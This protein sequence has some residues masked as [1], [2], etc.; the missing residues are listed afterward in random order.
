MS[1]SALN[2]GRQMMAF[3]G[4]IVPQQRLGSRPNAGG[5]FTPNTLEAAFVLRSS[6]DYQ[7]EK[8]FLDQYKARMQN[9]LNE[10]QQRLQEAY[11]NVLNVSMSQQIGEGEDGNG[12][13]IPDN[14]SL[15]ADTILDGN[16]ISVLPGVAGENAFEDLGIDPNTQTS[17]DYIDRSNNSG[18]DIWRAPGKTADLLDGNTFADDGIEG[19]G[20]RLDSDIA[21]SPEVQFRA[22]NARTTAAGNV[23]SKM[24]ITMRVEDDPAIPTPI[25]GALDF[26]NDV[27]SSIIGGPP[28]PTY[29]NQKV[30]QFSTETKTGGFWSTVNYLYNFAPREIK[31]SYAVGYTVNTDE[32]G[33]DEYL[34]DGELVNERDIPEHYSGDPQ[35]YVT[36]DNR[37]KW[38]SFDPTEGYQHERSG[39]SSAYPNVI[40]R[41]RVWMRYDQAQSSASG[42][43][44]YTAAGGVQIQGE[45]ASGEKVLWNGFDSNDDG[46]AS[47]DEVFNIEEGEVSII[48]G[49]IFQ[50]GTYTYQ[51]FFVNDTDYNNA[52]KQQVLAEVAGTSDGGGNSV[53]QTQGINRIDLNNDGD[54]SDPGESATL[55]DLLTES[56]IEYG[57]LF[58]HNVGMTA[59]REDDINAP[60]PTTDLQINARGAMRSSL[61]Y[62]HYEVETRTVEFNNANRKDVIEL[63]GE[64]AAQNGEADLIDRTNTTDDDGVGKIYAYGGIERSYSIDASK[65]YDL[66]Q[67]D[68]TDPTSAKT[69]TRATGNVNNSFN[70]EFVQ[71]LHKIH[72]VNGQ[73]IVGNEKRQASPTLGGFDLGSYE[74][75]LKSHAM[76]RNLVDFE[77]PTSL[78][79]N[80]SSAV[81]TDWYNAELLATADPTQPLG[82]Q[83]NGFV[84]FPMVE[85][86]ELLANSGVFETLYSDTTQGYGRE[87][88]PRQVIQARN[89]F[90]LEKDELM[91]LEPSTNWVT[92]AA[93]VSRPTYVKR[94]YNVQFDFT[95]VHY[96]P[97]NANVNS[98]PNP[99][100]FVNGQKVVLPAPTARTF[101][102]AGAQNLTYEINLSD[103]LQTG[104]NTI[105]IQMSDAAYDG[106]SPDNVNYGEGFRMIAVDNGGDDPFNTGD[107]ANDQTANTTIRSKMI[108]GYD[109]T[110]P[111]ASGVQVATNMVRDNTQKAQSRW[112]T[113]IVPQTVENDANF[114]L[115]QLASQ[116]SKTGTSNKVANS[117]IEMI[118]SAINEQKYRDIFKLGLLSNLNKVNLTGQASLPNGASLAGTVTMYY[119]MAS[120]SIKLEQDKLVANS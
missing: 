100:I 26:L 44:T 13:G 11:T 34:I 82:D 14:A 101:P 65:D 96:D 93:G 105:A 21:G 83:D 88:A 107:A 37:V 51:G 60:S 27:S 29:F 76:S 7:F 120:Q 49:L 111:G 33:N 68:P 63:V 28:D 80:A 119:D 3:T 70:G 2:V 39:T 59:G 86:E 106:S 12:D 102:N 19:Y 36:K 74:G 20:R 90:T 58:R 81:P 114:K 10:L 53:I 15:R 113:R 109:D 77:V 98:A 87:L 40:N 66:V 62:N 43:D 46:V 104:Y 92:D 61:F 32:A 85:G 16:E 42:K 56:N 95:N 64:G 47:P 118:I 6:L 23:A 41:K 31:Y 54:T 84:W 72:S 115:T 55:R 8:A 91:Q 17:I 22:L 108:T 52:I 73:N 50:S 69:V 89:T 117:F 116:S 1:F 78:E 18:S 94:D 35:A 38:S 99:Q 67:E 25:S 24:D 97:A 48:D 103:Y 110:L 57:S 45:I 75:L 112:S 9:R 71:T 5:S 4:G 79:V 30:Q